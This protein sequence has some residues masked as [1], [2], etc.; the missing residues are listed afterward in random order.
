MCTVC[1]C[2]EQVMELD[3]EEAASQSSFSCFM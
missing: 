3:C 1:F 2:T